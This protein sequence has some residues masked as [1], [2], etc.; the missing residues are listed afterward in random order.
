MIMVTETADGAHS[1]GGG[2]DGLHEARGRDRGRRG[3]GGP[4]WEDLA[5]YMP[6]FTSDLRLVSWPDGR[7]GPSRRRKTAE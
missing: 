5:K 2:G 7:S 4:N 6:E 3:E 1:G